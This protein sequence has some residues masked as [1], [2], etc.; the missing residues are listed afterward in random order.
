M[1]KI[2][3]AGLIGI[4]A[5]N[6]QIQARADSASITVDV[7]KP[8]VQVSPL[9]YGIF[10]EDINRSGDGGLYAEMLQNRSFEDFNVPMGW[11][12]LNDG[13]AQVTMT[14]DKSQPLND[15]NPTSLRLDITNTGSTGRVGVINQGYKGLPI[16]SKDPVELPD[17]SISSDKPANSKWADWMKHFADAQKRP[18][19]G[20]NIEDGKTYVL[21]F[22]ARTAPNFSGPLT[23]TLEKQ[24]GTVLAS[25]DVAYSGVDWKKYDV[26]LTASASDTNARFVLSTKT[27]GT[28]W[29]DQVSLFP[30]ETFNQRPNGLRADLM[31]MLLVLHPAFIRFPGGS[32]GEGY[33]LSEAFRWKE[34]I[35]D[36]VQ[37]PGQWNIWGYRTTN[38][39]GYYEYLQMCEDLKAEPLFVI[40]CG[41]AE[42]D[43]VDPKDLDPWIQ[44]ALD[45]ID[46][47]NG[48]A[49]DA[50]GAQ[51]AASGHPAPFNLKLM[52]L[53]NENGMG[54]FWGG[55]NA[56]QYAQ[57]YNPLYAK[58]K[59]TYPG[60]KT[61]STAPIQKQPVNAPVET[62][63]EHYYP[64]AG[65]FEDH[66]AMYDTYD[67]NG[68]KIYVGEYATKPDAGNGNLNAALG[69]AAFMTGMERNSD[70]V[71]MSSYAPLFANPEWREWNPNLIVF[72]SSR[73]YGTPSYYNQLLFAN[74]R[75][76][77]VLPIDLQTSHG[78]DPK[79][80]KPL[81]AVAGKKNDT[82]EIIIKVVNITGQAQNC[83]IQLNGAPFGLSASATVL[84]SGKPGD[85]NS[86]D[87]PTQVA[88]KDTDL[89]LVNL[90]FDYT[91][92]PY[93]ITILHF[94][95]K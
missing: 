83:T 81:Y 50:W 17:E 95:G 31:Q 78:A 49:T 5:L 51:R 10:F 91:L 89:G 44:D 94:K 80:R 48:P 69:E 75:P 35:G 59:A 90:P 57:R 55:G 73:A 15:K 45:A 7:T 32:F 28:I 16:D 64:D 54:Y 92:A 33:R 82:G 27:T 40:N 60:I 18:E 52:E 24:D 53:G 58:V 37:R 93:S 26:K 12:L 9:L 46:Y 25:Q 62:V 19:N 43:S 88:P 65:W 11:T 86:F 13:N 39:L 77:V 72:D 3:H 14:L 21:S 1:I 29:L 74:N 71:I 30:A 41:M 84:T 42:Q 34:T 4:L 70:L 6:A 76:D 68:P 66:A 22:Y 36:P 8:G 61:I 20:L 23:A 85:E 67:R 56:Q 2:I 79:A 63:D 47:A 38:G 87:H